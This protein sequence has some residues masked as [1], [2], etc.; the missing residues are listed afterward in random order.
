MR[1]KTSGK[2]LVLYRYSG[3]DGSRSIEL[4]I[5]S[6]SLVTAPEVSDAPSTETQDGKIPIAIWENLTVIEQRKLILELQQRQNER[7]RVRLSGLAAELTTL[8]T[9]VKPGIVGEDE[10][11]HLLDATAAFA[12]SLRRAGFRKPLQTAGDPSRIGSVDIPL[13]F[14]NRPGSGA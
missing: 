10:A 6:L 13:E 1:I 9:H 11:R 3:L 14:E 2:S 7:V 12:N 8:S 4:K 5:G